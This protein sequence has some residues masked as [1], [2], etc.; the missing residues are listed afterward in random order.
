MEVE[1]RRCCRDFG[2]RLHIDECAEKFETC[3][4]WIAYKNSERQIAMLE[5]ILLTLR[6]ISRRTF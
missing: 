4:I 2:C 1:V 6:E 3:P 5:K